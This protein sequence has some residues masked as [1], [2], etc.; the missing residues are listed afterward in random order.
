MASRGVCRLSPRGRLW[1]LAQNDR[2]APSTTC[3]RRRARQAR[4][5]PGRPQRADGRDGEVTDDTRLRAMLPTVTELAD[6]GAIVLLLAHFGRPKGSRAPTCRCRRSPAVCIVLGRP[7]DSSIARGRGANVATLLPGDIAILEN[8]RFFGGEEKNDPAVAR[9]SPRSAISTSTTPSPPRTAPT[10]RPRPRAPPPAYAGRAM[11]AELKAL[12]KALGEPER[13]VAAVVGGAKVSTKLDVLATSSQGRSSDHRRR[14]G[15]HLP[16]RARRRCRQVALRA[17]PA[18]DRARDPRLRG[19]GELHRPP[20]LR[21]RRGEGIRAQPAV[22]SG[23]ATS[24]R[25]RPTR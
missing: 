11:E 21:R 23:P 20:A 25:S 3:R 17:R 1:D 22:G 8:T 19:A 7:V 18:G 15:Q 5:R 2:S 10:P 6:K 13:P 14:N 4:A 12:E 24:T 9:A 16:R